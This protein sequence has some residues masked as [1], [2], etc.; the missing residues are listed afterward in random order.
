MPT[1]KLSVYNYNMKC[2]S[3]TRLLVNMDTKLLAERVTKNTSSLLMRV[4]KYKYSVSLVVYRDAFDRMKIT[5]TTS[6]L[7][8]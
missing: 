3:Y 5:Y 4:K 7:Y 8:H 2:V 1:T 6:R